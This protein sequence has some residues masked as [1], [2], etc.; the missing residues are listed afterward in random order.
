MQIQA[1]IVRLHKLKS[2]PPSPSAILGLV[3]VV[4]TPF[5]QSAIFRMTAPKIR[6]KWLH[7]PCETPGPT[8]SFRMGWREKGV[9]DRVTMKCGNPARESEIFRQNHWKRRLRK[10]SAL[11]HLYAYLPRCRPLLESVVEPLYGLL[12]FQDE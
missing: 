6:A 1:L 3:L 10:L 7:C 12:L 8:L 9:R 11:P 2:N 4:Y 5:L